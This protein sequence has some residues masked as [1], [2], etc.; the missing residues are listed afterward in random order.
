MAASESVRRAYRAKVQMY[1]A[2]AGALV[3]GALAYFAAT[4]PDYAT[5]GLASFAAVFAIA[6]VALAVDRRR[7][8]RDSRRR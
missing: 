4:D 3:L 5:A 6:A 8:L 2:I 1:W 7:H